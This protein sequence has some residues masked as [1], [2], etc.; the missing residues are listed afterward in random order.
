MTYEK[1][2]PER[3]HKIGTKKTGCGCH[4]IIKQYHHTP[5]VLGCYAAKHD[6]KIGAANIAYTCLSGTA[7][8]QIKNMLTQKIDHHQIMSCH[9]QNS[10]ATNINIFKG[11][12]DLQVHA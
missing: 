10:L 3:H 6:H 4:I 7:W 1:K 2:Y 8:E 9:T 12:R 5:T 11:T